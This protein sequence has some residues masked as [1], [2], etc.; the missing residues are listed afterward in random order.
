MLRNVTVKIW[1]QGKNE[2]KVIL[3]SKGFAKEYLINGDL[4]SELKKIIK[5]E[6]LSVS[7]ITKFIPI[8]SDSFT[9]Y[10]EAVTVS[11]VFNA[12]AKN[13]NVKDLYTAKYHKKPNINIG[14]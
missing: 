13:I 4:I 6:N 2:K 8:Q 7:D 9:G 3:T 14:V 1:C 5:K 11:N 12:F 10:R